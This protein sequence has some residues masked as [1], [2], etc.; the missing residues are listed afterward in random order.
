MAIRTPRMQT[1]F[2]YRQKDRCCIPCFS[3]RTK[4]QRQKKEDK[5][6]GNKPPEIIIP[7]SKKQLNALLQFNEA[8]QIA[9]GH[10]VGQ[11]LHRLPSHPSLNFKADEP[12][13]FQ[14]KMSS[15]PLPKAVNNFTD[16][17]SNGKASRVI[18]SK[19]KSVIYPRKL[20][21]NP[22]LTAV[23]DSFVMFPKEEFI[24][25]SDLQYGVRQFP[26]IETALL[27]K[28]ETTIFHLLSCNNRFIFKIKPLILGIFELTRVYR[29][30]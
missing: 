19:T 20:S 5:L 8:W 11:V 23:I 6:S 27:P 25:Y 29:G 26:H 17:S 3:I 22:K 28:N 16:E 10:Y 1:S 7:Y 4:Y 24:L 18:E 12:V 15:S 21:P 30:P 2:S 14:K 13:I 9:L